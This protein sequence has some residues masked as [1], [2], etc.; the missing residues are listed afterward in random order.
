ML[1]HPAGHSVAVGFSTSF[2]SSR[3]GHTCESTRKSAGYPS[4][5]PS[6]TASNDW[7]SCEHFVLVL[8]LAL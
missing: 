7:C 3:P 8:F 2:R 4:A 6:N 5:E 1:R